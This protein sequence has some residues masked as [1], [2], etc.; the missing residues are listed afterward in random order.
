M[1]LESP[2]LAPGRFCSL[3]QVSRGLQ[4]GWK[5]KIELGPGNQTLGRHLTFS[6]GLRGPCVCGGEACDRLAPG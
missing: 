1:N 2:E 6:S 3:Y 4:I 5:E